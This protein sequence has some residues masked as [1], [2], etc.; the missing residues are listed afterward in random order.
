MRRTLLWTVLVT[1]WSL[2]APLPAAER[3]A[4]QYFYDKN[5]SILA[6]TDIQFPSARRGVALGVLLEGQHRKPVVAVTSDGGSKWDLSP[7]KG[8][9]LSLF[10][11]NEQLGWIVAEKGR[12]SKTTDGGRT[13]TPVPLRDIKAEPARIFFLNESR[14]WLLCA[15]KQV[16]STADGGRSWQL[17]A[18]SRQ[19]DVPEASTVYDGAAFLNPQQGLLTGWSRS[20]ERS[21]TPDWMRPDRAPEHNPTTG[22][23]LS[24]GDAGKSWHNSVLRQLGEIMCVRFS[25]SGDALML[26]HHLA[27]SSLPTE[28][29]SF[30]LKTLRGGPIY[31]DKKRFVTDIVFAGPPPGGPRAFAAA[32][33]QEGRTP[34]PAI[35]SKIK[36]LQAA[37]LH[38]WTEM[39]VDY[40]AEAL[41][42][43]F[44]VFESSVWL[45][46][47]TGMILKLVSD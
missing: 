43:H 9:G 46:T 35:P 31:A 45:A 30:D 36:V 14:G 22:I 37:D 39:E 23:I 12:L 20:P 41:S 26:I 6:F 8:L 15:Q 29:L 11:L 40:R 24:T 21:Q 34:F 38:H 27:S 3:W 32:I 1:C 33:D 44:A 18:A 7:R 10:F 47:D 2:S 28:I 17:L 42:A 16:Y 5:D 4:L 13:W 25:S 19:P